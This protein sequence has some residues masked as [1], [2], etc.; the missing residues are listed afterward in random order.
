[1]NISIFGLGYVGCVS[2]GCLARDG[3]RVV[4]VDVNNQ[5]I[6]F[7]NSGK[8]P[9][10]EQGM[11]EAISEQ[12][13]RGSISAT[14][15][16]V[17]AVKSTDVSFVCVGTPATP[18]GHLDLKAVFEVAE[19]IGEGIREK[20][21]FHIVV[22]RSTVMPGTIGKVS[23]IIE[24]V[25]GKRCGRSFAVVSNPE[26]LREGSAIK[27]YYAPPYILIG[28]TH[29]E[30]VEKLK[31]I[32]EGIDS[33]I[34]VTDVEIAELMKYVSNAFH[35]LKVTFANEIGNICKKL[36]VDSSKLME[37]FC[38][39]RKLNI[40]PYYLRP[41]FSYGGSCLPKDLKALVTIAH[42]FYVECPVLENIER[43]NETHKKL[44]CDRI[45]GFGKEKLGFLGLSFKTGTDDLRNSPVLDIIE[46][47]LGKG[48]DVR[49]Y[50]KEVRFSQLQGTNR[51]YIL[52]KLPYISKFIIDDPGEVI[53]SSEVIVVV[54]EEDELVRLLERAPE[55]KIIFDLA[56]IHLKNRDKRN[57]Y[58]GISWG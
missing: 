17:D 8:S 9:I 3:H 21:A 33:P 51:E 56:D 53:T 44:V 36:D 45:V 34:I 32:Y 20:E 26:F 58:F 22:I 52:R 11:D 46:V 49:I 41:G 16:G 15:N 5:K 30:S 4:G 23:S 57:N 31:Q 6:D 55:D 48:F 47:L 2:L 54:N 12:H 50:D 28:A 13:K 39:D 1:M 29:D 38:M 24:E 18:N 37:V 42:D 35:A 27:D 14:S 40:S 10:V 7:I 19:E 25:S 43:S